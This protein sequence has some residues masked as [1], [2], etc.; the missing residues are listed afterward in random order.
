MIISILEEKTTVY[1]NLGFMFLSHAIS[2][3]NIICT[4]VMAE[5]S[6]FGNIATNSSKWSDTHTG[7]N[8]LLTINFVQCYHNRSELQRLKV[9]RNC[10]F[11][12][13]QTGENRSFVGNYFQ[14]RNNTHLVH[15]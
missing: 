14:Q 7:F 2:N 11:L 9:V 15:E 1:Y 10:S 5:I 3:D 6:E 13:I 8:S 4:K 12:F